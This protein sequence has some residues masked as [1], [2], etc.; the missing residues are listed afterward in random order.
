MPEGRLLPAT[1]AWFGAPGAAAGHTLKRGQLT[2][3]VLPFLPQADYDPLLW[4]CET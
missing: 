4:L 3:H 1:C 2:L